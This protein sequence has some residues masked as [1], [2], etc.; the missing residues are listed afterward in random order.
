MTPN[1]TTAVETHFQTYMDTNHPGVSVIYD[2]VDIPSDE[3]VYVLIS[4]LASDESVP[5]GMGK[6]AKSRNVGLIQVDAM[7]PS[8][9]GAGRAQDLAQAAANAFAR[10]ELS[11]P[12]EGQLTFGDPTVIP[13]EGDK[14]TY[15]RIMRV[16][17]SYDFTLPVNN[18]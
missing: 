3:S 15:R 6:T 12:S 13:G 1:M 14:T 9:I 2:N 8:G 16:P 17:Y 7:S 4:I 18:A 11:V 5:V 10:M